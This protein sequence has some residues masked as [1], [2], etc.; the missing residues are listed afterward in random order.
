[1]KKRTA[2]TAV[3]ILLVAI[4]ALIVNLS[5]ILTQSQPFTPHYLPYQGVDSKIYALSQ[6]TSYQQLNTDYTLDNGSIIPKGSGIFTINITLRNDYSTENPPPAP[7]GTPVTPIDGTAYITLKATLLKNQGNIPAINLSPSDFNTASKD[8][9]GLILASGQT[10]NIQ[11]SYATNQTNITD[12]NI[13][14]TSLT[15][16]IAR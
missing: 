15:D 11:L 12:Y 14:L 3:T 7:N 4:S 1:M 2:I 16:S 10:A 9:T 5:G 13:N 6:T 8:Q